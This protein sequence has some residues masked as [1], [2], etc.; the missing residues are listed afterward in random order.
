MLI[1]GKA[2]QR[3]TDKM[4]QRVEHTKQ[5]SLAEFHPSVVKQR[6]TSYYLPCFL[7]TGFSIDETA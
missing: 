4:T 1:G 3:Q 7:Y 6:E 5:S 2:A